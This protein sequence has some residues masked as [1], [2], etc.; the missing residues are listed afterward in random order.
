LGHQVV[1][2]RLFLADDLG[3][4]RQAIALPLLSAECRKALA[5]GVLELVAALFATRSR[6]PQLA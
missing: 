4:Q 3:Q 2:G 6:E 1:N 5:S